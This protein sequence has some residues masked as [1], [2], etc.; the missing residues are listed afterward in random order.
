MFPNSHVHMCTL[1]L[2][3]VV[4]V[5]WDWVRSNYLGTNK[6]FFFFFTT[7]SQRCK[8]FCWQCN[9]RCGNHSLCKASWKRQMGT[10]KLWPEPLHTSVVLELDRK[11]D[12]EKPKTD[13][14]DLF[15]IL[16]MLPSI[17]IIENSSVEGKVAL[18]PTCPE[19]TKPISD[20]ELC[21]AD[22]FEKPLENPTRCGKSTGGIVCIN[23]GYEMEMGTP[24]RCAMCV[25]KFWKYYTECGDQF[26]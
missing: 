16:W 21:H 22:C 20:C 11:R 10:L 14:M 2:P 5:I 15:P 9:D 26:C 6:I 8:I 1:L 3:N 4:L 24:E 7:A 13:I 19:D 17:L 12:S 23:P 18:V 25:D